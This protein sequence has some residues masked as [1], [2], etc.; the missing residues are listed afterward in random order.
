[1]KRF[2]WTFSVSGDSAPLATGQRVAGYN[3]ES[4]WSGEM[5]GPITLWYTSSGYVYMQGSVDRENGS[6]LTVWNPDGSPAFQTMPGAIGP[7]ERKGPPWFWPPPQQVGPSAPW[8]KAGLSYDQ[9]AVL[10]SREKLSTAD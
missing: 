8:I 2:V 1:M 3:H 9:W 7:I 6:T 4:R 10:P 5:S